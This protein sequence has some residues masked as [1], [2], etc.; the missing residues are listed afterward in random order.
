MPGLALALGLKGEGG[1][2]LG[3][4]WRVYMARR[5]RYGRKTASRASSEQGA[6]SKEQRAMRCAGRKEQW[7]YGDVLGRSSA[8]KEMG[9]V[10]RVVMDAKKCPCY[11]IGVLYFYPPLPFHPPPLHIPHPLLSDIIV[12]RIIVQVDST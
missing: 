5:E 12:G 1:E 4:G 6:A 11:V 8:G 7:L 9:R 2:G 10:G 3:W